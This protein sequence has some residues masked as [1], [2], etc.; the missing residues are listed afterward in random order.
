M[1]VVRI[2]GIIRHHLEA[3]REVVQSTSEVGFPP[4]F[5]VGELV[6]FSTRY[7]PCLVNHTKRSLNMMTATDFK[8]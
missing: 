5:V 3:L 2:F 8:L 4:G 7:C 6:D 1:G